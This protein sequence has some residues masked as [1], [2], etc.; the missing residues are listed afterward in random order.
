[1]RCARHLAYVGGTIH[2]YTF[3]IEKTGA[4]D[5]LGMPRNRIE[6]NIKMDVRKRGCDV[7]DWIDLACERDQS[8][9]IHE[10]VNEPWRSTKERKFLP[11][12]QLHCYMELDSLWLQ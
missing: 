1:M 10:R 8:H 6:F 3:S 9:T 12:G 7:Q 5:A 2:E 4:N 11:F